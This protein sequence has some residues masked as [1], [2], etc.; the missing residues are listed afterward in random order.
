MYFRQAGSETQ[1]PPTPRTNTWTLQCLVA[2]L[3]ALLLAGGCD[4]PPQAT[5]GEALTYGTTQVTV[6]HA[7]AV[8]LDLETPTGA[9]PTSSPLLRMRIAVTNLGEAPLRYDVGF[10]A[11]A[12]TQATAALLFAGSPDAAPAALDVGHIPA[13]NLGTSRYL[14]DP[15]TQATNIDPGASLEDVLLFTLPPA[16]TSHLWLSLPPR[17]FGSEVRHAA[18]ISIPWRPGDPQPPSAAPAGEPLRL[19]DAVVSFQQASLRYV[20]V[21]SDEL[22]GEAYSDAPLLQ[23]TLRVE[24]GGERPISLAPSRSTA[25]DPPQLLDAQGERISRAQFPGH[26]RITGQLNERLALAPGDHHDL[27]LYFHAPPIESAMPLELRVPG[28]R[29]GGVGLLR[30]TFDVSLER[31][32]LPEELRTDEPVSEEAQ[33]APA[34]AD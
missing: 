33:T 29:L 17:L 28:Q 3:A 10:G 19:Q 6:L 7:E 31:P 9:Q 4:R 32:P 16:G 11:T 27:H 14:G 21:H 1:A 2:S 23:V 25:F 18:W 12:G 30:M 20:R 22:G 15:V 8:Y 26:A 5:L 13:L 34:D 24:N